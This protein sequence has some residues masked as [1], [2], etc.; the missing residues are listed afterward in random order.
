VSAIPGLMQ[1]KQL[2][3][4]DFIGYAQK[5]HPSREIV[6]R[7]AEGNKHRYTYADAGRESSRAR[8]SRQGSAAAIA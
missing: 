3:I 4:S 5:Y 6:S 7:D 1:D 2:M 8:C